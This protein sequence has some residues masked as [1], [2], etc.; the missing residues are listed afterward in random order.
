MVGGHYHQPIEW[1]AAPLT[2]DGHDA[3]PAQTRLPTQMSAK[4]PPCVGAIYA[5]V[6]S[7][8]Y[9]YPNPA[10]NNGIEIEKITKNHTATPEDT[11]LGPISR[12]YRIPFSASMLWLDSLGSL[13]TPTT[14]LWHLTGLPAGRSLV[15]MLWVCCALGWLKL[16]HS[17]EKPPPN[18][19]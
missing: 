17:E 10:K 5:V 14:S 9:R 2:A 4:G 12:L 7:M 13:L 16:L 15:A 6:Q 18:P 19:K 1:W 11:L 3:V 8:Q